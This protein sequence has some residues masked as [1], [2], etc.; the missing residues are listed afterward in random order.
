METIRQLTDRYER[1]LGDHIALDPVDLATKHRAM[2]ARRSRFPFFRATYYRW[3]QRWPLECPDLAAAPTVLAVGDLHV[4]NFGT[5]RDAEGRLAWG[6]N[7]F[8][9]CEPLPY[10][11][12]LV[13]LAASAVLAVREG[14]LRDPATGVCAAILDG[15]QRA[16]ARGGRPFVLNGRHR[17]LRRLAL[18]DPRDPV[19]F[20]AK[21]LKRIRKH[22]ESV[23]N[24]P[25]ALLDRSLPPE[26]EDVQRYRR[27]DAGL[28]SLGK[29]RFAA[30]AE[31]AGGRVG[32][33]VKARTPPAGAFLRGAEGGEDY[34][35]QLMTRARRCP[36]PFLRLELGWVVRRLTPDCSRIDLD[37]LGTVRSVSKLLRAMGAE[38]A[39]THLATPAAI[40]A[41]RDDLDRRPAGWLRSAARRMLE[42]VAADRRDWR[43]SDP[44]SHG[45]GHR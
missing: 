10:T 12:D 19:A 21:E 28:G 3:L 14:G 22:H 16:L 33:E 41:V 2:A 35:A 40:A 5:W 25:A 45:G 26:A 17:H 4:E 24:E 42:A 27:R 15:Y 18:S 36:D 34:Y 37:A 30:L 39:N 29:P 7:D 32:R 23:V 9:E 38:T 44:Q 11:V 1:W 31:W 43:A 20:W 6:V 8:D 13:R